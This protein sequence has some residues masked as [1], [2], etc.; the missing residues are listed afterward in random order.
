MP[1]PCSA[2]TRTLPIISIFLPPFSL[3]V[4]RSFGHNKYP[5]AQTSTMAAAIAV[6]SSGVTNGGM[7]EVCHLPRPGGGRRD[8]AE[9]EA[10]K[11]R[12]RKRQEEK[13]DYQFQSEGSSHLL[14]LVGSFSFLLLWIRISNT[15]QLS[16]GLELAPLH[17]V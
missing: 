12:G 13:K 16:G 8:L 17:F 7:D 11:A 2:R 9:A 4:V 10:R 5:I 1:D 14:F 3:D 6:A 15:D